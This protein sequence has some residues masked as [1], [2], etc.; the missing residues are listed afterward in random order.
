MDWI[1]VL[2]AIDINSKKVSK[3]IIK[4][5]EIEDKV[6]VC[7]I[8]WLGQLRPS[9]QYVLVVVKVTI[10][11]NTEKLLRSDDMILNKE[12]IIVLLFKERYTPVIYFRCRKFGY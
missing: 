8:H 10:K 1:E 7:T 11:K 3:S 12:E 5:F 2:L 6:E 9:G 4:C